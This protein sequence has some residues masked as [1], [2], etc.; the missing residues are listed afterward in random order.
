MAKAGSG[1]KGFSIDG[2]YVRGSTV[3][4][5][6]LLDMFKKFIAMHASAFGS[7]WEEQN[8]LATQKNRSPV[9]NLIP[10]YSLEYS[11]KSLQLKC[12]GKSEAQKTVILCLQRYN[13]AYKNK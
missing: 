8:V 11:A 5:T 9:P 12:C 7:V 3:Y 6:D 1:N 13:K 2:F 4:Q 10:F